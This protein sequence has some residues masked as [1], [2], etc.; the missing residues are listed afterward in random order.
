MFGPPFLVYQL[1]GCS[2]SSL[3]FLLHIIIQVMKCHFYIPLTYCMHISKCI[4][5]ML[6]WWQIILNYHHQALSLFFSCY[7][8]PHFVGVCRSYFTFPH[9]QN[10]ARLYIELHFQVT[11]HSYIFCRCLSATPHNPSG[12][13]LFSLIL[14][15]LPT[16]SCNSSL[17]LARFI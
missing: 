2:L 5:Y 10:M 12:F 3:Q 8:I 4:V 1:G 17:L 11:V 6:F 16:G 15:H 14:H 9:F 7:Y 13:L